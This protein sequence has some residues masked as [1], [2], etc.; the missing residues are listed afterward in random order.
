LNDLLTRVFSFC[1]IFTPAILKDRR[2]RTWKIAEAVEKY[3]YTQRVIAG[4]LA[5]YYSYISQILSENINSK[6]LPRYP[7]KHERSLID[8]S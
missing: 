7:P 6:D 4:H 1:R 3:G 2:N 5:I 8:T